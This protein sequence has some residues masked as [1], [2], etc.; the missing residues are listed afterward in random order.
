MLD[1][2]DH[3]FISHTTTN[4]LVSKRSFL[5]CCCCFCCCCCCCGSGSG[6][7]S[8]SSSSNS[9]SCYVTNFF[10]VNVG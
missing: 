7:G 8:S 3:G 5:C 1:E 10:E 6:S 2:F 4:S 9:S